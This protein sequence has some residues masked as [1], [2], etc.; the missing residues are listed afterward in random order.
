[1]LGELLT[2]LECAPAPLPA[3]GARCGQCRA[4]LDA[5]PTGAFVDAYTL[6]ARRSISYLTNELTGAIPRELRPLV[7]DHVFGC[8]V[9]QE[10]CPVNAEADDEGP[11][12]V[13]LLPLGELLLTMGGREFQRRFADTALT[14]AGRHRLLRNVI[15]ALSNA[16]ADGRLSPAM[17]APIFE[18]AAVDRRPEV[19]AHAARAMAGIRA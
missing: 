10:V 6:D 3:H 15:C 13:P 18:R 14:R 5:C 4:C 7:G 1:V 19:A 11:L 12:R 17:A 2:D 9:C 16:I 8:D